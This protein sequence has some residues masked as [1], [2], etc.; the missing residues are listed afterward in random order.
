MKASNLLF[1]A[2]ADETD[3]DIAALEASVKQVSNAKLYVVYE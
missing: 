2:S 3:E 1:L